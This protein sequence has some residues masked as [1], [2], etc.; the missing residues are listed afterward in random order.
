MSSTGM[1]FV[2]AASAGAGTRGGLFRKAVDGE[3]W[4]MVAGGLPEDAQV[5]A[6]TVHPTEPGTIYIGTHT[7]PFRSVDG[8]ETWE[9]LSLPDAGLQVWSLLVHPTKPRT[10]FA[11]TSPVAVYRSDDGGDTWRRVMQQTSP[12]RVKMAFPCRVMRL[13][14]DPS[15]TAG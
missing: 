13:A 5:Q 12:D 1:V 14:A 6:I 3:A 15:S 7:G 2:G 10:L 9:E 11:G 8:G 4:E